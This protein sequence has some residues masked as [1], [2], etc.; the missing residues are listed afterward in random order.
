M[1]LVLLNSDQKFSQLQELNNSSPLFVVRIILMNL[2]RLPRENFGW[3][4][5]IG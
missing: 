4:F 5:P 2:T 1:T 3:M